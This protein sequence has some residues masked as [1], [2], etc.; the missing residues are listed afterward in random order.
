VTLGQKVFLPVVL[1]QSLI[2]AGTV[3]CAAL[4]AREMFGNAAAV[5]AATITALYPYYVVHD[6]ALQET[7]LYTFLTAVA[8]L[9]LLRAH[10][11]GLGIT[12][13][14]A[15]LTLGAAVLTRASL[16]PFAL[17]APLWLA[18]PGMRNA[19]NWRQGFWSATVCAGALAV[20][21]SPWLVRS[22]RLTGSPV[23]STQVGYLLWAGNNTYTFSHYPYESIDRSVRAAFQGFDA[24]EQSELEAFG[25]DEAAV[26]RWFQRRALEYIRQN[27]WLT[28][29]NGFRKLG[30]TFG[31]LPSPRR[32]FWPNLVH[33]LSYGPIMILG[34][35]GMWACRQ[36]W[37]EYLIFYLLFV[38]FAGVTVLFFGHTSHRAYLDIYWIVFAAGMLEQWRSS[39]YSK[40]Q[41]TTPTP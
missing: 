19:G 22:Y 9:L 7:S 17:F 27:P 1:V 31:W 6:T 2:G 33:L 28:F 20:T 3:C 38:S 14:C 36:Y 41:A 21:L 10:R 40:L 37:H 34:L 4:L 24:Q 29:T 12:A 35:W 30:A 39:Y 11:S 32:S 16:A 8:M 5:T 26:D 25:A 18:F 23:L 13:A 15:G